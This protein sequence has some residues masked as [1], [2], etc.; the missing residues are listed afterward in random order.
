[1]SGRAFLLAAPAAGALLLM[2]LLPL[3]LCFLC[4]FCVWQI[5]SICQRNNPLRFI[6]SS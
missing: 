5:P 3:L 2:L 6:S 1:V 4:G